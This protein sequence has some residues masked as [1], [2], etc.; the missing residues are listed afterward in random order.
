MNIRSNRRIVTL[1][2]S[3]AFS[4]LAPTAVRAQT[5]SPLVVIPAQL[6]F[7]DSN[8]AFSQTITLSSND[9]LTLSVTLDSGTTGSQPPDWL[10][11]DRRTISTPGSLRV[12][13][14]RIPPVGDYTAR[15]LLQVVTQGVNY[16]VRTIPVRLSIKENRGFG[17]SPLSLSFE[18]QAGGDLLPV[19][20]VTLPVDCGEVTVRTSDTWL[21][22]RPE[23]VANCRR[24][25]V[26]IRTA[27]LSPRGHTSQLTLTR[28]GARLD[29]PV[30]VL[31]L[32][33]GGWLD[34]NPNGFQFEAREGNGNSITRNLAVRNRGFGTLNWTARISPLA[35]AANWLRLGAT[36]GTASRT[37][38]GRLPITVDTTG[39]TTN[40][41]YALVE[42]SSDAVL[43]SPQLFPIAFRLTASNSPTLVTP[44]PSGLVFVVRQGSGVSATQNLTLFASNQNGARFHIAAQTDDSSGWLRVSLAD[45]RTSTG[46]PATVAVSVAPGILQ[47]GVYQ[48]DVNAFIESGSGPEVRSVNVTMIVQPRA[49]A[50]QSAKSARRLEGCT[51]ARL[52][53][54]H[55]GLVNNFVTRAGW[56]T[57]LNVRVF[58]DCGEAVVG[59]QVVLNFSN[60]DVPLVMSDLEDGNYS[61]TWTPRVTASDA[62]TVDAVANFRTLTGNTELS[63]RVAEEATPVVVSNGVVNNFDRRPGGPQAP[64]TLVEIFGDNLALTTEV[65]KLQDGKLP[66]EVNGVSVIM[67]NQ[68]L[69]LVAVSPGQL[70]A[71]IP[72][73]IRVPQ[74]LPLVVRA[75]NA[76]SVPVRIPV[77]PVQPGLLV[78]ADGRLIAHDETSAIVGQ[79]GRARRG[80]P[81]VLYLVGMGVTNP[82]LDAG[83]V[84]PGQPL[85]AAAEAPQVLVDGQPVRVLFAGLTPGF[86]GLYQINVILPEDVAP[87]EVPVVVRQ[88]DVD[89]NVARL[90]LE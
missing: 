39:L 83:G 88:G 15:V 53:A 1:V 35:G 18:G 22:V 43:N 12:F 57:P 24:L 62:M 25:E 11:V 47:P 3:A 89:S 9:P 66:F 74:Q 80:R 70:N 76:L 78:F 48:G 54:T 81:I 42:V 59:A 69:P 23:P 85:A 73:G 55:T 71:Q 13:V 61:A 20:Y 68:R 30:N 37:E 46:A 4:A 34:L 67:G 33:P 19:Q 72:T 41:Y 5:P 21:L 60:G 28:S 2:V 31:L 49:Q 17:V 44:S 7:D 63:G 27:N 45:G 40:N 6:A 32:P 79:G 84:S 75:G 87:G 51:P 52:A 36:S 58:D 50:P 16:A 10:S 65:A 82:G 26:S 14:S 8:V 29:I 86:V 77:Q 56:P 38:P 90:V 64:G